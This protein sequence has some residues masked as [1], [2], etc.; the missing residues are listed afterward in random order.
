MKFNLLFIFICCRLAS[1]SYIELMN[2][3]YVEKVYL[4]NNFV[5]GSSYK[6]DALTLVL[7]KSLEQD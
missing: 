3:D 6:K 5:I 4:T 2:Y 1:A 7:M